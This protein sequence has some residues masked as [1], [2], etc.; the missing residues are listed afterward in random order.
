MSQEKKSLNIK[1]KNLG[2][3]NYKEIDEVG[4]NF[5]SNTFACLFRVES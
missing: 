5:P 3:T 2:L 1:T 4:N